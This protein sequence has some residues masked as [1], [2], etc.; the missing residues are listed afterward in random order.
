MTDREKLRAQIKAAVAIAQ[1]AGSEEADARHAYE[2]AQ[3]RARQALEHVERLL[4]ELDELEDDEA[5]PTPIVTHCPKCGAQHIDEGEF[6]TKPHRRHIC[7]ACE[8]IWQ[9]CARPTVGVGEVDETE[10]A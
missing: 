5:P 6:A 2:R 7:A 4:E 9:P 10:I 1:D 3:S 8:T